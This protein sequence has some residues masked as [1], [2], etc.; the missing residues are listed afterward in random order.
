MLDQ[1]TELEEK[2][3]SLAQLLHHNKFQQI[4]KSEG[5]K[6]TMK[7][8]RKNMAEQLNDVGKWETS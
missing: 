7:N 4:M 3:T 2:I 1:L 8:F 6:E 5:I